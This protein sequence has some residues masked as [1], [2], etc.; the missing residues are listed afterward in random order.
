MLEG[1]T[2]RAGLPLIAIATALAAYNAARFA[3]EVPVRDLMFGPTRSPAVDALLEA[4]G[5]DLTSVVLYLLEASWT[6][7]IVAT[8][9][10]PV[11]L[12]LLGSSA[13]HAAARMTDAR[14]PYLPMLVFFAYATALT[15]VPADLVAALVP[16]RGPGAQLAQLAGLAAALWLGWLV[17][18]GIQRHYGVDGQR[19]VSVLLVAVVLFYLAPLLLIVLA[20]V[21]IIVAAIVLEYF[22]ASSR[23]LG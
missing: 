22:P 23:A 9:L 21:A 3:S 7:L 14:R 17:W 6:A 2:L 13:V 11:W 5:R 18:R 10:S 16:V 20:A 12:W 15:R 4:L 19:A 1:G 8:A